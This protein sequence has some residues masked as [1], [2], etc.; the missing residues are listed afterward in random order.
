M[1]RTHREGLKEIHII[2]RIAYLSNMGYCT[3]HTPEESS[4][5]ECVSVCVSTRLLWIDQSSGAY[6]VL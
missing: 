4:Q 6:S 1:S 3:H 2:V 5:D